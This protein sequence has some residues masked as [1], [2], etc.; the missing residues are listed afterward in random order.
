VRKICGIKSCASFD[1]ARAAGRAE[2]AH[3]GAMQESLVCSLRAQRPLIRDRW[4]ALLHAEPIA[5]PLGN[6][7][8]LVHLLDWTLDEIFRGLSTLG[9]RRR[10]GRK[11][12]CADY[13]PECACGRN[14]LLTYFLA[15]EQ[16]VR[17]ALVLAQAAASTLDPI[18]R[19][20]SLEELDL[21]FHHIARREI[22]AF[23]GVCQHRHDG[24]PTEENL[25]RPLAV[26]SGH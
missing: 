12:A 26:T 10:V 16:A 15:G 3:S 2:V 14:P 7:S 24:R 6:P 17:E 23:C 8:A 21:V 18:E 22:E 4:E 13:R 19:D 11:P 1:N 25:G 20:A 9:S 5:T